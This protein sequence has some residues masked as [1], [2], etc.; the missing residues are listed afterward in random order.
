MKNRHPQR[1]LLVPSSFSWHFDCPSKE[2]WG[3]RAVQRPTSFKLLAVVLRP[4]LIHHGADT[5]GDI[6]P[7]ASSP[8]PLHCDTSSASKH[9]AA[10][11]VPWAR[12]GVRNSF[13]PWGS[14]VSVQ[15]PPEKTC[16]LYSLRGLSTTTSSSVS[17]LQHVW[18]LF[19]SQTHCLACS[20]SSLHPH[21]H[22]PLKGWHP[23]SCFFPFPRLDLW[24]R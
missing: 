9:E 17:L 24:L 16:S 2:H 3:S 7:T 12:E 10:G 20:Y 4:L 6:R 21:P 8:T 22:C 23:L 15:T 11:P 1:V 5:T 14:I 19:N 18:G 13:M